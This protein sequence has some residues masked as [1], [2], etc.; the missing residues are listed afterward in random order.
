MPAGASVVTRYLAPP[1]AGREGGD[2]DP[3]PTS[4]PRSQTS[5]RTTSACSQCI[6]ERQDIEITQS[7]TPLKLR[8]DLRGQY[9]HLALMLVAWVEQ[10][11]V[12][13][14]VD[15]APEPLHGL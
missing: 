4:E 8:H 6:A 2:A 3:A 13:T 5:I 9:L 14:R 11:V 12:D 1:R 7:C 10:D 15:E